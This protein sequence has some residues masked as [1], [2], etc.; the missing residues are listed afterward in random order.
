[1]PI[2][3]YRCRQCDGVSS[4]FTRAIGVSLDPSCRHCQSKD[5]QRRM[6]TFVQG[7]TVQGVHQRYPSPSG[8]PPQDYY[9]DPRNIGRHVEESFQRYGME[10]P[11]SVR[12]TINAAREGDLPRGMDA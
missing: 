8:Q 6:S 4:F 9:S 10:V 12:E 1:M 7:K 5:L 3:E 2:Y 11:S